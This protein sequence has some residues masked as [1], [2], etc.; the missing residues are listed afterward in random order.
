AESWRVV[1]TALISNCG[2]ACNAGIWAIDANPRCG[3]APTIPTRIL[4]LVAIRPS[5]RYFRSSSFA[6][7]ARGSSPSSAPLEPLRRVCRPLDH[8]PELLERDVG[9]DLAVSGKRA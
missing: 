3:F 4:L 6:D 8:R 2:S 1:H 7:P 9:L 5:R